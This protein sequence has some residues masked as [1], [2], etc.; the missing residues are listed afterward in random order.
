M[1]CTEEG[2]YLYDHDPRVKWNLDIL[3]A[4]IKAA[5]EGKQ[6]TLVEAVKSCLYRDPDEVYVPRNRD[7]DDFLIPF[8]APKYLSL[9][10]ITEVLNK[11]A[12]EEFAG[13]NIVES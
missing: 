7:I 6:I 8:K 9:E 11:V 5:D 13:E 10:K 2:E 1:N 12:S 4:Y 3:H